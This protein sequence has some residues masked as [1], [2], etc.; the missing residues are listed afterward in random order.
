MESK[1]VYSPHYEFFI[2]KAHRDAGYNMRTFHVHKKY[3]IYYQIDGTRQYYI[4]E[5]TYLVNAGS[6]VL[7]G[8][9]EVHKTSSVDNNSHTRYVLNFNHLATKLILCGSTGSSS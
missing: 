1:F 3:E 9:D 5:D 2:D 7:I 6:I 4:N 8:T